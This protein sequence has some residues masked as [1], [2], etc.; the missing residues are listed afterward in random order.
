MPSVSA[1]GSRV[2]GVDSTPL[3][4]E[5]VNLTRVESTYSPR[6]TMGLVTSPFS[7]TVMFRST[8]VLP[9][10]FQAVTVWFWA[11]AATVGVPETAPFDLPD[12]GDANDANP[13]AAEEMKEEEAAEPSSGDPSKEDA[14][15]PEE[16][17][18]EKPAETPAEASE[19]SADSP[20]TDEPV[21]EEKPVTEV[22]EPAD[23]PASE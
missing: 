20:S 4:P 7:N 12:E 23:E 14:E 6:T 17:A 2:C 5:I 11:A 9:P 1:Y 16:S 10:A 3:Y 22:N 18:N 13:F 21:T 8:D 15:E 19:E